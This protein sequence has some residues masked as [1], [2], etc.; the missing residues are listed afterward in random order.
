MTFHSFESYGGEPDLEITGFI[1]PQKE[2]P[3]DSGLLSLE[4][5]DP[6]LRNE[7]LECN[8]DNI[9]VLEVLGVTYRTEG[10]PIKWI[11]NKGEPGF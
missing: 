5:L 6:D 11:D 2:E 1:G 7:T 9:K 3:G 10:S 8:L 4:N